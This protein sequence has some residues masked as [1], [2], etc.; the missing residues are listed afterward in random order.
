MGAPKSVRRAYATLGVPYIPEDWGPR[1]VNGE[2]TLLEDDY[3]PGR[4]RTTLVDPT[5][6]NSW[7]WEDKKLPWEVR[8]PHE[9]ASLE[10]MEAFFT[11]YI[12]LLP[13][14]KGNLIRALINDR[15]TYAQMGDERRVTRQGAWKATR[16]AVRAL[17]RLI[18]LD[19]P[20]F[21]GPEDR[22]RRD[23][24]AEEAAARRVYAAYI[25]DYG[26]EEAPA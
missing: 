4:G 20:G 23:Y 19:D 3:Y 11:P 16:S 17:M 1:G 12:A 10:H 2:S 21:V 25:R 22:R 14:P 15:L 9:R 5:P 18:A 8:S 24:A 13:R 6:A 7:W 26:K